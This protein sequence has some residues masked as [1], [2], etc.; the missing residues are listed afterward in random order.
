MILVWFILI[1][2]VVI[3]DFATSNILYSWMSI[4][5]LSALIAETMGAS[6]GLQIIL[7]CVVGAIFFILGSYIS[8]KYLSSS[9]SY[10]PIY[11]DKIIGSSH[12]A[13][14]DI[15]DDTQLK[16][17]G[18]YWNIHNEGPKIKSGEK[19]TVIGIK[20]NRLYILKDEGN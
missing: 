14:R 11:M 12:T 17:S 18:I 15:G 8:K 6:I 7:A 10:T 4:G 13:E 3:L 5:F 16:I 9:I 1:V 20:N 2:L 19:F